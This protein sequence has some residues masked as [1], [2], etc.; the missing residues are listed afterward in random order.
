MPPPTAPRTVLAVL[1]EI[2]YSIDSLEGGVT[3]THR[4]VTD[5]AL[6]GVTGRYYDRTRE[7]R[8]DHQAYDLRARAELWERSLKL[9]DHADI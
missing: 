7:A 5:P 2:G 4:L 6:D 1:R 3:A 9:V 8:A